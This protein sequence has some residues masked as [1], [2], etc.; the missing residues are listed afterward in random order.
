MVVDFGAA[1]EGVWMR[2]L[3]DFKGER[4]EGV[5]GTRECVVERRAA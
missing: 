1:V 3:S 4:G 5:A 2:V